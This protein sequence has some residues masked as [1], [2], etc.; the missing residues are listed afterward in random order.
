MYSGAMSRQFIVTSLI[1][2]IKENDALNLP[3]EGGTINIRKEEN[4]KNLDE[5]FLK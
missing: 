3:R 4:S 1:P 5:N 2:R